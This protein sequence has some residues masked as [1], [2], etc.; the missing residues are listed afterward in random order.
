MS[1]LHNMDLDGFIACARLGIKPVRHKLDGFSEACY[2][3]NSVSELIDAL[4]S[5]AADTADCENWGISKTAW[6]E[7][8]RAAIEHAMFGYVSD[9]NLK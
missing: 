3:D 2:N 8:I 5:R 6:R 1:K 7:E 9:N 4:K